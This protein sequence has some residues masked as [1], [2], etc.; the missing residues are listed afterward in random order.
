M[1]NIEAESNS[2]RRELLRSRM[3]I[4][5]K[6]EMEEAEDK[7]QL[8]KAYRDRELSLKTEEDED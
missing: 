1:Q 6:V 8:E 5:A 3:K 4:R 2:L 7:E